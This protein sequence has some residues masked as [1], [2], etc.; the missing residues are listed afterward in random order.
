MPDKMKSIILHPDEICAL[1]KTGEAEVVRTIKPQPFYDEKVGIVWKGI[2]Y[3]L[4]YPL[5]VI[6]WGKE[7]LWISDCGNYYAQEVCELSQ[8]A[9][10][11]ISVDT[12]KRW[13]W[14]R[15]IP[16]GSDDTDTRYTYPEY[17]NMVIS[18]SWEGRYNKNLKQTDAFGLSFADLDKSIKIEIFTGNAIIKRYEAHF[19]K[20]ISAVHMPREA[21]RLYVKPVAVR[22]EKRDIWVW[23][24]T[25]KREEM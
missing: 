5:N 25:M 22:A 17:E 10:D 12:Y 6:M 2:P 13:K 15:Y 24:Y 19:K 20:K 11:V 14:A 23:A 1:L 7:T 3:G 16:K 18:W 8:P 21:C 4:P 9:Y